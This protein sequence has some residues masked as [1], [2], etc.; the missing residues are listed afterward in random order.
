MLNYI[1]L[2]AALL[3]TAGTKVEIFGVAKSPKY[4]L[5]LNFTVPPKTV[6]IF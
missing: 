3:P 4:L 5:Y 6:D 1:K 2:F